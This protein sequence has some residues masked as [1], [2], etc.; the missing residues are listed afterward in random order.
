VNIRAP[1]RKRIA[2]AAMVLACMLGAN[3]F[4]QAPSSLASRADALRATLGPPSDSLTESRADFLRRQ[5]LAS[6]ERRPEMTVSVRDVSALA[7]KPDA[8]QGP[9]PE[10][11]LALDD[12]RQELQQLEAEL[13]GGLRRRAILEQE[14][15]TTAAL[16]TQKL[17]AQRAMSDAGALAQEQEI[18]RLETE[19]TE[20]ATA[21]IDLMLRLVDVQQG[22]AQA[23]RDAI[24][25]RL[26]ETRKHDVRV[27][28]RDIA[29]IDARMGARGDELRRRMAAAA[30]TRERVRAELVNAPPDT[31]PLRRE[32]MKERV[33]NADFD[34]E[35]GREALTNLATEQAIWQLALRYYRDRDPTAVVEAR[36]SGPAL[37]QRVERRRDFL[38]ALSEQLLARSGALQTEIAQAPGAADVADKRALNAVLDAR[39]QMVHR[40]QFDEQRLVALI[41]RV[42]ADFDGRVGVATFEE[43]LHLAWATL[44]D[45]ALRAWN[46][47]L[48]TVQQTLE[49]DGRKTEVPRGVT[50]G[51]VVKA[52][53]LLLLGLYLA[54]KVTALGERWLHHRRGMD[55]GRARLMRRWAL[56]L[57]IAACVLVSL[58]LAGIPL[59]AF[60]F[61]GGAVAIGIGFGMQALFK[62][63][64]SGVLVLV[65]R[66][67]RLGDVIEVGALRGTVVDIDLRTSVVRDG[68]GADTL[69][70]NSVL[71]EENVKNVTFRSR[72]HHQQLDVVVDAASDPR[73][74]GDA[75]RAAAS[76]H[77][78][79]RDDPEPTVLL[80]DFADNG[81]RFALHYWVELTPGIDRRR[82]ASDLRLMVL[83][84]FAD[85]GIHMAPPPP[86]RR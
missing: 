12:L 46:V 67:F 23:K 32:T 58:A 80:E 2:C 45:L 29:R 38:Q 83:G 4:A 26:S 34:L 51:K 82:I 25:Q 7:T 71:M 21:E 27:S 16:L 73:A 76:R 3:V 84:A 47:E 42:R 35:L 18:A 6:L 69:I 72:I 10:D 15:A 14:R 39:L 8:L 55:E 65:E 53:L 24:V 19:L 22:F 78:Q 49:V 5:L 86:T 1:A 9:P 52:P 33:A 77:G 13:A 62:N 61:I 70:P 30:A 79:L 40:A 64:I 57:L 75:L 31:P 68:D 56:A 20:S 60:A 28:A 74:V 44:R 85:T 36:E 59:A 50:V 54:V 37:L 41:E 17:S 48:F 11:L 63:L 81:L 43:R 66:P